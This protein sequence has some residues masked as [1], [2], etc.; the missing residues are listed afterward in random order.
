MQSIRRTPLKELIKERAQ[1]DSVEKTSE[2]G[3]NMI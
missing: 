2:N 1:R 3:L